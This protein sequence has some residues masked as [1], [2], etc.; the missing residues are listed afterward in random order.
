MEWPVLVGC[1]VVV[2][3]L[4]C[5]GAL[6]YLTFRENV[7]KREKKVQADSLPKSELGGSPFWSQ[8][9]EPIVR[10]I[11]FTKEEKELARLAA[12]IESSTAASAE[13]VNTK[14][15]IVEGP[16]YD[17]DNFDGFPCA[18]SYKSFE[19]SVRKHGFVIRFIMASK[20]VQLV[21]AGSST[22]EAMRRVYKP[23]VDIFP[24]NLLHEENLKRTSLWS[25]RR[26]KSEERLPELESYVY[27]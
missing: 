7:V 19:E 3:I 11:P 2:G 6:I 4:L 17:Y 24:V 27:L 15:E 25:M 18:D 20:E 12:Q 13:S 5:V 16:I 9:R 23:P 22:K 21:Y 26:F 10:D 14:E 8:A 1:F